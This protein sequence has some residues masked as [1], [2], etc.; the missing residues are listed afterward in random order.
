MFRN[1]LYETYPIMSYLNET[2]R[3]LD[4]LARVGRIQGFSLRKVKIYILQV[5][6]HRQKTD[7]SKSW[8]HFCI[9]IQHIESASANVL[10]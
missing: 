2:I 3:F 4:F 5:E 7:C 8:L 10:L 1:R 9:F 6:N